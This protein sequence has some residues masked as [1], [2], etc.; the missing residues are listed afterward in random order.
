MAYR[1]K[2]GRYCRFSDDDAHVVAGRGLKFKRYS[3]VTNEDSTLRPLRAHAI[4][5]EALKRS[6]KIFSPCA[7][8]ESNSSVKRGAL[9]G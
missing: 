8:I 7:V 6:I 2:N 4:S 1:N 5:L 9:A 3:F